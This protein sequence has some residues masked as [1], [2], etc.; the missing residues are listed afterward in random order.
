MKNMNKTNMNLFEQPQLRL[1]CIKVV[2]DLQ[3]HWQR[4][5][6]TGNF[7]R[8][9]HNDKPGAGIFLNGEKIEMMPDSVYLL[10]PDCNLKV[11]CDRE[12]ISQLFIHFEMTRIMGNTPCRRLKLT[13]TEHAILH[14]LRDHA[15]LDSPLNDLR[16]I[17]LAACALNRLPEEDLLILGTD[18]RISKVCAMIRESPDSAFTVADLAEFCSMAPNSFLRLFREITGVTPYQY[19]LNVR[20]SFAARI[21]RTTSA[22]IDEVCEMVGVK[23]RFHFS[24]RFKNYYSVSPA[25]YRKQYR[26]A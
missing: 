8:L 21:L 24:R 3:A 2:D 19:I 16:A 15:D 4:L 22:T 18:E 17:H 12:K 26:M 9:Y 14:A 10:S 20:Y 11:W 13:E 25:A 23:D 5:I 6:L 1:D 7:W